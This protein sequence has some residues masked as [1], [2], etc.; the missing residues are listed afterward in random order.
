[1]GEEEKTVEVL[2]LNVKV[3][4]ECHEVF[5]ALAE[6]TRDARSGMGVADIATENLQ[7]LMDAV[8]GFDMMD[9]EVKHKAFPMTAGVGL[10]DIA[11]ALM[12]S[13]E[14]KSGE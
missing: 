1:M 12:E 13:K 14:D 8:K 2:D 6:I 11:G 9:D 10:G 7:H 5:K 4:K 3:T